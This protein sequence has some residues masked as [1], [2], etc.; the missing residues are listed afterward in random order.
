MLRLP[1]QDGA[2]RLVLVRH[3]DADES[4]RGRVYGALD[5]PLSSAGE[6]RA[7][8]LARALADLPLA[9]VYSSPL[10]RAF[11]TAKLLA[12][13]RGLVP[14][15]HEGLREIDFGELEGRAYEEIEASWNDLFRSWVREPSR[16]A[17][18]GGES[19]AELRSRAL[20]AVDEIR[21]LHAGAAVAIVAHGGVARAI[22]A[23]ALSLPDDALFRIDQSLGG[24]SVVDWFEGT[25]LVRAMNA[26]FV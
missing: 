15:V 17:F 14:V 23:D 22:L 12:A 8:L 21:T 4:L 24:V 16:T 7:G 11:A 9:A 18:P 19:F 6:R 2:T 3:L 25:P 26:T 20:A 10:Q 1:A 13:R 5:V